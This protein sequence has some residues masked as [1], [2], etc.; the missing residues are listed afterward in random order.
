MKDHIAK[1]GNDH[2]SSTM[3][4]KDLGVL[5]NHKLSWHDHIRTAN[6]MLRLIGSQVAFILTG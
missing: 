5:I 3:V 2:V 4:V 1:V 6:K